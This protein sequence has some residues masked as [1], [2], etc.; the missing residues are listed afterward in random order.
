MLKSSLCD[1]IDAYILVSGTI[2]V[3]KI[4]A[5]AGNNG[6]QV[7]FKNCAPFTNWINEINNT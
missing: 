5:G 4:E 6:N 2:I 7:V 3:T 1:Y